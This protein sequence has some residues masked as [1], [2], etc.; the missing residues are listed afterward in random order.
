[1]PLSLALAIGAG[2]PPTRSLSPLAA[3]PG[4][5]LILVATYLQSR[6]DLHN[7]SLT[8]SFAPVI[9]HTK[10]NANMTYAQSKH[11][12]LNVQPELYSTVT[13]SS[14]RQCVST[15]G[16]LFRRADLARHVRK[17]IVRPDRE[18]HRAHEDRKAAVAAVIE[19]AASQRLDALQ[20]FDWDA[21]EMPPDDDL[22][23]ALRM[24]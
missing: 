17:L 12:M 5:L 2:T 16:M 20:A 3:F 1:M 9:L 22:W 24:G 8:V 19:L 7:F 11:F 14:A 21:E 4:D 10:P 23:F 18:Q 6:S 15:L 13:L